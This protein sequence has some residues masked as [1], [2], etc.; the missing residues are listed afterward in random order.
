MMLHR[1]IVAALLAGALALA[2]CDEFPS[3]GKPAPGKC[4]AGQK[5]CY[6]EPTQKRELVLRCNDGEVQGAIWLID[7]VCDDDQICE[8]DQCIDQDLGP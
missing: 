3:S 6:W 2:A 8:V 1:N 5:M 4:T 7:D